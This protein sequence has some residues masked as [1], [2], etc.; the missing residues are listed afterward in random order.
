MMQ[1]RGTQIIRIGKLVLGFLIGYNM[2]Q[3][4]GHMCKLPDPVAAAR[5][6]D[7]R[8]NGPEYAQSTRNVALFGIFQRKREKEPKEHLVLYQTTLNWNNAFLELKDTCN[9]QSFHCC[10]QKYKTKV[11][12]EAKL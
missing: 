2:D 10:R 11:I 8:S 4:N 7:M 12:N 6:N 5:I 3:I 9:V 1:S